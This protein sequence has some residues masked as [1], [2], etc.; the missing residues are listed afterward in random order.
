MEA[1]NEAEASDYP[2]SDNPLENDESE[3]F[4]GDER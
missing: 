1:F 2:L 4:D 3:P